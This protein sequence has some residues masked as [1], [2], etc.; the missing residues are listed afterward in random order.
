M[1]DEEL[2][3]LEA[4]LTGQLRHIERLQRQATE[5]TERI[6]AEYKRRH[7]DGPVHLFRAGRRL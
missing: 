6:V 4:A 2:A 5:M 7:G 1:T 3:E